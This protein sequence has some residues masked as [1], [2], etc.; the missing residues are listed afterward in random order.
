MIQCVSNANS[1]K[2]KKCK[3]QNGYLSVFVDMAT[4]PSGH[5]SDAKL[6]AYSNDSYESGVK[7]KRDWYV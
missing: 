2:C 5:C 3:T 7:W 1:F 6:D 4:I